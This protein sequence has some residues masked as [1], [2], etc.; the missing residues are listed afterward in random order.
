MSEE[1][2]NNNVPAGT[3]PEVQPI[4]PKLSYEDLETELKK[5]RN[6]AASRRVSLR[7][8]EDKAKLWEEYQESQKTELQKLQEALEDSKS[9]LSNYQLGDKK[10]E[11][12]KEFG[13]EDDDFDLL[14]GSDEESNRLIAEKLKAKNEKIKASQPSTRPLDLLAGN[15]GNPIG[16]TNPNS[17][18]DVLR[19]MAKR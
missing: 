18:D 8:M 1:I 17:F 19:A 11:L 12:L 6:E 16:N 7:E 13:L 10:R 2:E 9:K 3:T 15:R 5:V 14:T 4:Q